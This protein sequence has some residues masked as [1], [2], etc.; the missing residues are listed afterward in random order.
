MNETLVLSE[1]EAVELL[2]LL[3]TS[4]RTQIDEPARYAPLRLLTTA[5]RLA[6]YIKGR[7]SPGAQPMLDALLTDI[8]QM[9][10]YLSDEERYLA[11]LDGL[12]R[13]VAQHLVEREEQP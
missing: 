2:A 11:A 7:A 1:A 13:A 4:S 12:C 10:Y 3:V 9:R 5:E 8:P 6:Q